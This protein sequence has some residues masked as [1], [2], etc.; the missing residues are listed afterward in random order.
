MG[1]AA[2]NDLISFRA[3]DGLKAATPVYGAIGPMIPGKWQLQ[4]STQTAQ[5]PWLATMRP[6]LLE[7]AA[8]FRAKPPPA[9]TSDEYAQDL[10]ETEAYGALNSAVRTK[11]QTDIAYFWNG[12]N[13]NQFNVTMQ[14]VVAQHSLDIDDAAHLFAMGMIVTADAGIGCYDSKL[15]YEAWRPITAIRNADKDGNPD[16]TADPSWSP[17]LSTP[18]HPEYPSQHGCFTSAFTD[19][20][21]A[22]LGTRHVDVTMPGGANGSSNLS[23]TQHFDTVNEIQ[24]QEIDA[25]VCGSGSTSAT[26]SSRARSSATT[27]PTGSSTGTSSRPARRR[28]LRG[29]SP[30]REQSPLPRRRSASGRRAG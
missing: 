28:R 18:A 14:N 11:D 17:L 26:R 8:Q 2:A 6:F 21:A 22:A 19:A 4:S 29:K 1:E 30:P 20:L 15:F 23:V 25:R 13:V 12:N 7:G 24:K 10:N 27:W 9:I 16:T 5:T 3:G